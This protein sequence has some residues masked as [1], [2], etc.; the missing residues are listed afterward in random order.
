M[1]RSLMRAGS[2]SGA[3]ESRACSGKVSKYAVTYSSASALTA[4]AGSMAGACALSG[5]ASSPEWQA[6]R[7]KHTRLMNTRPMTKRVCQ[8]AGDI[9]IMG[10][11]FLFKS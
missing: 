11:H 7:P 1:E 6:P 2:G 5:A 4:A 10:M 9:L 3:P 8:L